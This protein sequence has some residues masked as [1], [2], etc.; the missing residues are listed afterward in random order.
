MRRVEACVVGNPE[1]AA[2][3]KLRVFTAGP[4]HHVDEVADVLEAMAQEVRHLGDAGSASVLKL[5]LNLVLGVQTVGLAEAVAFAEAHDMSRELLL[6]VIDNSGWRSPV[7][8]FRAAFMRR[9]VYRPAGFRAV[10]MHKDLSLALG[11][12]QARGVALPM[13]E[14]A[15]RRLQPLLARGHGDDDAAAVADM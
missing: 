8:G 13:V 3:G 6:D 11:E 4:D 10:L 15:A 7:L 2:A 9:R 5:A 12:A 14:C 1:M